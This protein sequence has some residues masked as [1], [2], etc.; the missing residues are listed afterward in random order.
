[1]GVE[2][3]ISGADQLIS[4][5]P[6]L[7]QNRSVTRAV[8]FCSP[9]AFEHGR[10]A[11]P[12]QKQIVTWDGPIQALFGYSLDDV[13]QTEEWWLNK[14][15]SEDCDNV[16]ES[17]TRHL[18][19]APENPFAAESRIWG[20]DYR[21]RHAEGRYILVSDR[22]ITTR[23]QH[24]NAVL[25]ESVVF[26]KEARRNER[27]VHAKHLKS[28]NLLALVADNTP[29]GIFMMDPQG[30][31]IFMNSAAE[32]ITGFTFDEIHDY[33]FH[34]SV[35]SCRPNGDPFPIQE[36]PV[37]GHQQ[38]G[39]AAKNESEIFVHKDGHHYDIE[40]SVSPIGDYVS[41]GAVIEFRDV[42]EQKI[43]E[44]ERLNAILKSEQQ[45]IRIKADDVHKANMTS[46]V[47]FV[48]HEIRNPLQ[49]ITSSA[50][51][52]LE[53]LH[54]LET[55]ASKLSLPQND[56]NASDSVHTAIQARDSISSSKNNIT[57]IDHRPPASDESPRPD[58]HTPSEIHNFISHA[59]Q[60]VGNIQ[61]CAEHQ[62]LITNNVLDLSRLD[63]GKMDL[64]SD[65]VDIYAL[66][67]QTV[68]MM[69]AKAQ[70]KHINLS[71]G[72]G[73]PKTLYLKADA[74]VLRQVLLNLVSNAI[75]FTPEHGNILIDLF[76]DPPGHDGRITLHGSVTDNGLG[77]SELEQ[78]KLFQRFSQAN[79]RYA[80]IL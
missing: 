46:F 19:A 36:C 16:L 51:F 41:G 21:F 68:E 62:A 30:Y 77:M 7:E 2:A 71:M 3:A 54:Q 27:E 52:L 70:D 31:C 6:S 72:E 28:Q 58:L 59:K 55:L 4:S 66:G 20:M 56:F 73:C 15:H 60:L 12:C 22:T 57:N 38:N 9:D 65:V 34:A 48:C 37:Y 61:T 42:T 67:Q 10:S 40:Y 74:T 25:C 32:Q 1:M 64:S 33:T 35:H 45:S 39:T 29:S 44:R 23:D 5:F 13:E 79:R 80:L 76:A 49:G 53:T 18:V 14:I 50:E 17:L 63:A 8:R 47:S 75:K 24:G 78:Q 69:L 43:I 26:D 11:T